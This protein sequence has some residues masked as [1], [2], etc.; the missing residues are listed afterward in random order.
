MK[1]FGLP[2]CPYC[3]LRVG[4][5]RTWSLKKQGEYR[6]IR[7]GG[8]SNIVLRRGVAYLAAAAILVS[9][10]IFVFYRFLAG[11]ITLRGMFLMAAPY[12][13]FFVLSLFLVKLQRPI[14]RNTRGKKVGIPEITPIYPEKEAAGGNNAPDA[15]G[16]T[17]LNGVAG[18]RAPRAQDARGN[19]QNPRRSG[20]G[21]G[22]F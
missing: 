9:I 13:V 7:C 2:K 1:R 3:G 14:F 6:C 20:G 5:V 15:D 17:D 19:D 21:E 18:T 10:G 12:A 11:E 4:P 22:Y 16:W 8:I